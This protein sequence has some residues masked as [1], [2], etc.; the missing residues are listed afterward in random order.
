MGDK[1]KGSHCFH[2][3]TTLPSL[4]STGWI[5]ERIRMRFHKQ[6]YIFN[7][8]VNLPNGPQTEKILITTITY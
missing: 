3:Q 1:I 8:T 2:K 5:Q 6:G 4:L 7:I